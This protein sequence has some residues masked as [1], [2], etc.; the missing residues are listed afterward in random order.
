MRDSPNRVGPT[1]TERS[2]ILSE[3]LQGLPGELRAHRKEAVR[4]VEQENGTDFE[5]DGLWVAV[6]ALAVQVRELRKSSG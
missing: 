3:L 5:L 2:K 1:K 4:H 6:E